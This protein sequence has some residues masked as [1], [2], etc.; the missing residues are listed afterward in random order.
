MCDTTYGTPDSEILLSSLLLGVIWLN[1]SEIAEREKKHKV[2]LGIA[3]TLGLYF[4]LNM[5]ITGVVSGVSSIDQILLG[6]N[7]GI[8]LAFFCN[9]VLKRP[10]DHHITQLMN[11]EY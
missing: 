7:V 11:G 2:I 1:Q 8:L 3:W 4:W 5:M 10:L 6:L 9:G